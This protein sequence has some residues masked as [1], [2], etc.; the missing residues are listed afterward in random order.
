MNDNNNIENNVV[1]NINNELVDSPGPQVAPVMNKEE[2]ISVVTPLDQL[3]T[4]PVQVAKLPTDLTQV[5]VEPIVATNEEQTPVVTPVVANSIEQQVQFPPPIDIAP[6]ETQQVENNVNAIPTETETQTSAVETP[7]SISDD[8]PIL[9]YSSSVNNNKK[10]IIAV[11]LIAVVIGA[12]Y[13]LSGS[14]DSKG[15]CTEYLTFE[16]YMEMNGVL[17]VGNGDTQY[18]FEKNFDNEFIKKALDFD[19]I[20]FKICYTSPK[21]EVN[22]HVGETTKSKQATSIEFYDNESKKTIKAKNIG[23]L[24]VE[25]GICSSKREDIEIELK[26]G[27]QVVAD[28]ELTNKNLKDQ[29]Q[30]NQSYTFDFDVTEDPFDGFKYTITNFK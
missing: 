30:E 28:L 26:S 15:D 12:W 20:Q 10:I 24:L 9:E 1:P 2:N 11:L 27:K 8:E 22:F 16:G 21:S 18:I 23:D 25:L 3:S 13:F 4:E 19:N 17:A 5:P 29:L 14:S 6:I 7:P